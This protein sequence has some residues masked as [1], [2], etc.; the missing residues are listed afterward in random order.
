M[1]YFNT[2]SDIRNVL[3]QLI[4]GTYSNG[5]FNMFRE[6]YDSLLNT[7]CSDR[8]DTYFILADFKSYAEAHR[9]VEAA[10]RDEKG[11]PRLVLFETQCQNTD[12]NGQRGSFQYQHGSFLQIKQCF[13][14]HK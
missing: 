3:M 14:Q 13:N 10:Y 6:I 8:A 4:N 2:D 12:H 5:D 11:K 9:K 7:N 1:Y